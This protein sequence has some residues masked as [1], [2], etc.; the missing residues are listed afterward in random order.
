MYIF[1]IYKKIKLVINMENKTKFEIKYIDRTKYDEVYFTDKYVYINEIKEFIKKD[2]GIENA[3][4]IQIYT[5]NDFVDAINDIYQ[6]DLLPNLIKY[7]ID[8]NKI[9]YEL[10]IGGDINVISVKDDENRIYNYI[11]IIE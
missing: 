4:N 7:A 3:D 5:Y 9:L 1:F 8:Y 11:V 2:F 10:D 6:V